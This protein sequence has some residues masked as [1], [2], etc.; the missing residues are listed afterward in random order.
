MQ[1]SE[2]VRLRKYGS[3]LDDELPTQSFTITSDAGNEVPFQ[4][5]RLV[6]SNSLPD[7]AYIVI[8]AGGRVTKTH[9]NLNQIYDFSG[10]GPGTYEFTIAQPGDTNFKS[11]SSASVKVEIT[12]D[13]AKRNWN[14]E[15]A[16]LECSN[17]T[18]ANQINAS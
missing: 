3:V 14:Y 8:P 4:G 2:D 15:R 9:S 5:S 12:G 18:Y 7:E 17:P 1:G 11:Q 10:S 13:T 6:L 16:Y